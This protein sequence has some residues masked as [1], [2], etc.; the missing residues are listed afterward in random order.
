MIFQILLP[1]GNKKYII[2]YYPD[3]AKKLYPLGYSGYNGF[4]FMKFINYEYIDYETDKT[5]DI[6]IEHYKQIYFTIKMAFFGGVVF[7]DILGLIVV[8]IK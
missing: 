3:I 1:N 2:D 5:I 7:L 6:I 4:R 8:A